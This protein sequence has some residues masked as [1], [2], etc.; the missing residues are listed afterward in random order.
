MSENEGPTLWDIV[1]KQH[2]VLMGPGQARRDDPLTSHLAAALIKSKA[3]SARIRLLNA[4]Y[5][6]RYTKG[7]TD[8]EAA[9]AA[10]LS[11]RSEYA[12]RCSELRRGGLLVP[13]GDT[14]LGDSGSARIVSSITD[15]GVAVMVARGEG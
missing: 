11:L 10:G 3:T 2:E 15:A 6:A 9:D 14:R 13:T 5:I 1:E 12:T 7:L 4:F 8:E